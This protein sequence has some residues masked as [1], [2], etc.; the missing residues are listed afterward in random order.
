[1]NWLKREE[2]ESWE[3]VYKIGYLNT[4]LAAKLTGEVAVDP[5]IASLSGLVNIANPYCWDEELIKISGINPDIL[6]DIKPSFN[7][8]GVLQEKIAKKIGLPAGIPVSIGSAD[9]AAASFALGLKQHGDVFE[10]MG[11]SGVLTFCLTKPEFDKAFMNRSHVIPGLWLAHGAMSTTGAA[12]EW[13]KDIF[14][15]QLEDISDM[16][17]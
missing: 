16:E 13:A 15:S 10:S 3:R 17:G 5:T 6:P 9:T 7:K 12:I 8:V 1:M 11:T 2:P 4:F 14:F